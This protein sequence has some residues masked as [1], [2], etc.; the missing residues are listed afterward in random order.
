[1]KMAKGSPK[2]QLLTAKQEMF[3][4]TYVLNGGDATNAYK[5]VYDVAEDTKINSI[6]VNAHKV[7]H[8]N[9]VSLRVHELQMMEYSTHILTIEERKRLLSKW[10]KK[11][12]GKSID[13]LNRMEGVYIEK[14]QVEEKVIDNPNDISK[15]IADG[16][17]D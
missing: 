1:M 13:M 5:E 7:L 16:L 3:A 4:V 10:A 6:Y 11:G 14:M 9:K 12:D 15:A 2:K 8:N 17:P